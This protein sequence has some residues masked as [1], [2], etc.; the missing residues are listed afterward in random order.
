M[1]RKYNRG[2]SES[3]G[4]AEALVRRS[5][6]YSEAHRMSVS[7]AYDWTKRQPE[8][9]RDA[10]RMV[11]RAY[12]DEVPTRLTEG[13][14][15]IGDDGAPRF[16]PEA[17]SYIFGNAQQTDAG[18]PRCICAESRRLIPGPHAGE[19]PADPDNQPIMS[20]YLAPF[21]ATL[22]LMAR[23]DEPNRKRAAIVSHIT[24]GSQG[25]QEA[26]IAED[27][28]MWCAKLVALDALTSFLRRLSDVRVDARQGANVA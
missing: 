17:T 27:V 2:P 7:V 26:A 4:N 14:G 8:S 1:T 9:L 19:C 16:A 13:P 6:P 25:P 18:R 24:I 11:R 20:Y 15:S 3:Q 12:A 21:R 10:V 5:A 28:P 23:G 22:D